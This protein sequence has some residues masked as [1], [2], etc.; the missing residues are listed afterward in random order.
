MPDARAR[1]LAAAAGV[2]A[3]H[4]VADS[5][6]APAPGTTWA[7]HLVPGVAM[8]AVLAAA[9]VALAFLPA[10]GRAVLAL[11]LG[12]LAIEGAVLAVLDAQNVGTTGDS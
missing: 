11:V 4:A 10:G 12:A 6:L 7:D 5:F 8:L 2:V 3:V 1:L 9:A